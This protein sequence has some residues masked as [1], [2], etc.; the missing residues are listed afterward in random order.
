MANIHS[1]KILTYT[2]CVFVLVVWAIA[3]HASG[4]NYG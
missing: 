2:F 4:T 3:A 1:S